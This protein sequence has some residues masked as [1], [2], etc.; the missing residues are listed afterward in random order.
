MLIITI[1]KGDPSP[2]DFKKIGDMIQEGYH[3]GIDQPP[4]LNW[5]VEWKPGS[6][7]TAD[8]KTKRR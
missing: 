7:L 2:D 8:R 4:G 6:N 3:V 1:Y 5:E